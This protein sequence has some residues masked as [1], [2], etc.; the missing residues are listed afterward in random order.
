MYI[1]QSLVMQPCTVVKSK[2]FKLLVKLDG[3]KNAVD[4]S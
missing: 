4:N 3:G 1:K 2:Y